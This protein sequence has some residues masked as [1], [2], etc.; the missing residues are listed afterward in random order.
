MDLIEHYRDGLL[1]LTAPGIA[2]RHAF[3]GRRG[4]VSTGELGSL[5]LSVRRGD[6]PARV[7]ENWARLGAAAGMDLS[8]AVYARQVHSAVVRAVSAA[9]LQPP[10]LEPRFVC[11]GFVTSEPGVPL[12]VFM[13]DCIPVLLHDAQTGVIGAAHCGWRGSVKDI[14]GEAVRQMA[15]LGA[16]PAQIHAAVGPG[17]GACCFEVGPEVAEGVRTLLG[18][19]VSGLIR[20]QDNGKFLLDLKRANARRLTQLGV[21]ALQIDVSE[22]CTMCRP[23]D[24]WSHRRTNGRRGVQAAVIAL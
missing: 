11:D 7:R 12:A 15:A 1:Y 3:A 22:A 23:G 10:E 4:G 2:A 20:A 9:D 21:P 8:R 6:E 19:D 18:G 14:L 5:N 17:I 16:A 24:F 13:A